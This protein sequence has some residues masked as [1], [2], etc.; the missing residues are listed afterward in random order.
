MNL[1]E[2]VCLA[3]SCVAIVAVAVLSIKVA[4]LCK[5]ASDTLEKTNKIVDTVH[6]RLPDIENTLNI[7]AKLP[8]VQAPQNNKTN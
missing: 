4:E 1:K 6:K 8:K 2:I 3:L 5:S 7:V